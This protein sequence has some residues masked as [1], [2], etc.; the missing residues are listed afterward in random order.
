MTSDSARPPW[1][2]SA[3]EPSGSAADLARVLGEIL[4]HPEP[5]RRQ[6]EEG[7]KVVR[8]RYSVGRMVERTTEHYR[9]LLNRRAKPGEGS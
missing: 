8:E 2:S 3:I 1:K 6:A 4:D 5:A 9:E 7:S